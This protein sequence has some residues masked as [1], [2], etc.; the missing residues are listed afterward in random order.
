[1]LGLVTSGKFSLGE[2]ISGY[3]KLEQARPGWVSLCQF[4]TG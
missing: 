4:S 3:I 2:E 1:M